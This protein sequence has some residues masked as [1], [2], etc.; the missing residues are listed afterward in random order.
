[1]SNTTWREMIDS[2]MR[3]R[4]DSWANIVDRV[5]QQANKSDGDRPWN[6]VW[7]NDP[8]ETWLDVEFDSGYGTE[9]GCAFTVWTHDWVY[10]PICYDGAEWVGSVPRHPYTPGAGPLRHQGG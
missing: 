10:F 5:G 9:E 6:W 8:T 3:L 1:M 7:T 2:E 4:S